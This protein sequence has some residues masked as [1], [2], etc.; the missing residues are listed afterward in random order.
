[1][2]ENGHR[3]FQVSRLHDD[4]LETPVERPV[5]LYDFGKLV[6]GR[7]AYTLDFTPRKRRLEHIGS[8]KTALTSSRTDNRM[9]LVDEQDNVRITAC[10]LDD[11]LHT[12]LEISAVFGSRHHGRDIQ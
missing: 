9:E 10:R 6:H 11:G 7:G 8:V 3:L 5:L 1:M 2:L 12:L 4:F